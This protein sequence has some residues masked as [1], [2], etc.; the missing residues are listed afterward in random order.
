MALRSYYYHVPRPSLGGP[1]V[2]AFPEA[3]TGGL[4]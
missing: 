3:V 4:W 2:L 1:Q